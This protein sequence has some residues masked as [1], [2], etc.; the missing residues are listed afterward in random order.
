MITYRRRHIIECGCYKLTN[1]E[2]CG[3][4][5]GKKS[6][7]IRTQ[8]L[9]LKIPWVKTKLA[10]NWNIHFVVTPNANDLYVKPIFFTKFLP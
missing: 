10:F 1:G 4:Y 5:Y 7:G 2:I 9:N 8:C 3:D 6:W